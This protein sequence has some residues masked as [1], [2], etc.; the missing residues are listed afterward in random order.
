MSTNKFRYMQII[1]TYSTNWSAIKNLF[2]SLNTGSKERKAPQNQRYLNSLRT[3]KA[4]LK[5]FF[6]GNT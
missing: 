1:L 6:S 5:I 4:K 2:Q 3:M